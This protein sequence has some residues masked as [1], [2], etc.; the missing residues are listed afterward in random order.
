MADKA[1]LKAKIEGYKASVSSWL[2]TEVYGYKRSKILAVA[3]IVV[4]IV[5]SQFG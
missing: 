4:L 2:K 5:V 1:I 3:A